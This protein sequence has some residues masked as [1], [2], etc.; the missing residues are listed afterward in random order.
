MSSSTLDRVIAIAECH[1]GV[2]NLDANS[3]IDQDIRISG[4]DVDELAEALH[5]EFGGD[6]A[7]W[8]WDRFVD[9]NEPS[10]LVAPYF[11][12]R[13]LTWPVRGRLFDASPYERLELVHIAAVIDR[14]GWFEP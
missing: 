8:P 9:L 14:G 6:I 2:K 1:S 4:G 13:L 10:L 5:K 11:I 7:D 12:W 3:A